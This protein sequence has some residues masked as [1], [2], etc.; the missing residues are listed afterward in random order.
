MAINWKKIW[1]VGLGEE[2]RS[3][4]QVTYSPFG[5]ALAFSGVQN[6]YGSMNI[7]AV[8]RAVEIISDSVA[9]LPIKVRQTDEGKKEEL[10]SHPLNYI[11]GN[12]ILSKYNLVKLLIQSV[13]LKGNGFAYI[14]RA[15][16]GTAI[17]L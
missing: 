14:R 15:K 11:F 7:S 3:I 13:L 6:L 2:K 4:E 12:N 16:D 8:Y 9:M 1:N 17:E 5:D 10:S